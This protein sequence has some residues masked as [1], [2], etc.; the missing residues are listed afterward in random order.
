YRGADRGRGRALMAETSWL[1]GDVGATNARFGLVSPDGELLHSSSFAIT[2]FAT[3][4][5][6]AA[7]YLAQRGA[8]PAP[9]IGALA[10]AGA[11]G[12]DQVRMTNHPWSFSIAAL[13]AE[14]GFERL[15]V[16]NDFTAVAL[17]LPRLTPGDRGER[18]VVPPGDGDV[19]RDARHGRRQSGAAL[20]VAGRRLHRRRH[21]AAARV[22][23]CRKRVPRTLRGQGPAAALSGGDPHLRRDPQAARLS[24]LHGGARRGRD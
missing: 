16:I 2:D 14:L 10:V 3:I 15:E 12:G 13:R 1:V 11:V 4:G 21:R 18:P 6:A 20:G 19:L 17:A 9:P 8:L 5:A 24:R 22:A 7:A 23:L